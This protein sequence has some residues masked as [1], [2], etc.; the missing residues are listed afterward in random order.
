MIQRGAQKAISEERA[1]KRTLKRDTGR[2]GGVALFA[3]RLCGMCRSILEQIALF[4][5]EFRPD[6]FMTGRL[7]VQSVV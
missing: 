2:C 1:R 5:R 3:C 4:A 6:S 7:N